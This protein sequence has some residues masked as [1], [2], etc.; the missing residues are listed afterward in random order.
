MRQHKVTQWI[1][2]V[3]GLFEVTRVTLE[4]VTHATPGN[5]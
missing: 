4:V 3:F 2:R 1:V 5:N